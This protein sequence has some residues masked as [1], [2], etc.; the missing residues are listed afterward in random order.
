MQTFPALNYENLELILLRPSSFWHGHLRWVFNAYI[1]MGH[2]QGLQR[3]LPRTW[4]KL[5]NGQ[6]KVI[7]NVALTCLVLWR[8]PTKCS[9]YHCVLYLTSREFF[10]NYL[11]FILFKRLYETLLKSTAGDS[12][13][14]C[15]ENGSIYCHSGYVEYPLCVWWVSWPFNWREKCQLVIFITEG[16]M[17]IISCHI[18]EKEPNFTC[19]I[20]LTKCFFKSHLQHL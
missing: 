6:C 1:F 12:C 14:S 20:H 2:C 3:R 11:L 16:H 15:E 4:R 5:P 7:W 18:M 9:L 10:Y 8:I 13:G 17:G 19:L